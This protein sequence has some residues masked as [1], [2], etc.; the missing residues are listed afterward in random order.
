MHHAC[1]C[2]QAGDMILNS[3]VLEQ[4]ILGKF[5]GDVQNFDEK[6]IN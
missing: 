5:F 6:D 2:T 1:T 4:R 3:Y